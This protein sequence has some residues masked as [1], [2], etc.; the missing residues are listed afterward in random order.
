MASQLQINKTSTNVRGAD[1]EEEDDEDVFAS[2]ESS[3][4]NSVVEIVSEDLQDNTGDTDDSI[5]IINESDLSS[6]IDPAHTVNSANLNETRAQIN[7]RDKE[8]YEHNKRVLDILAPGDLVEYKRK[9]YSHWAVYVG[10]N[11]IVHLNGDVNLNSLVSISGSSL[12][13][14]AKVVINNYWDIIEDSHAYKNNS[15]DRELPP[16]R[17]ADILIRAYSRVGEEYYNLLSF[18]CEHFANSCRYNLDIS[19]QVVGLLRA[20]NFITKN[21]R[22]AR[23][24]LK[25]KSIE[26]YNKIKD[27]PQPQPQPQPQQQQDQQQQLLAD[28]VQSSEIIQ[29][30]A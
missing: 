3:R 11:K 29:Q 21:F 30:T 22:L 13:G 14:S 28:S 5:V 18:N 10:K 1:R 20:G 27:Q 15:K 17:V 12:F 19:D 9:L 2:L 26:F 25:D 4:S 7:M 6:C 8:R 24:I 23:G 16:L